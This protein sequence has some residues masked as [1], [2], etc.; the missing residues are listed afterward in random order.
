[1]QKRN[2]RNDRQDFQWSQRKISGKSDVLDCTETGFKTD[3][4]KPRCACLTL[5]KSFPHWP[6]A[7][8]SQ[9]Q[10]ENLESMIA[11]AVRMQKCTLLKYCLPSYLHINDILSNSNIL[12]VD[13]TFIIINKYIC[14]Y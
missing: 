2:D 1:M 3:S 10:F 13:Q 12:I 8:S 9:N 6:R 5:Y 7:L 4:S 14:I 11:V